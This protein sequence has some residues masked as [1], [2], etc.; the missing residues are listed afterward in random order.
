MI[1]LQSDMFSSS[2]FLSILILLLGNFAVNGEQISVW[3]RVLQ[4]VSNGTREV[5]RDIV[6]ETL[7]QNVFDKT[8]QPKIAN[9]ESI[10]GSRLDPL[11]MFPIGKTEIKITRKHS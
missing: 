1:Y 3:D 10:L 7:I 6:M 4:L 8:V 9:G 5:S 11:W 2:Y